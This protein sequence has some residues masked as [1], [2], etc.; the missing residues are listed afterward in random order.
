MILNAHGPGRGINFQRNRSVFRARGGAVVQGRC[1]KLDEA[2]SDVD[3]TTANDNTDAGAL[4]NTVPIVA[5]DHLTA[6]PLLQVY[7]LA[8]EAAADDGAYEGVVH[9]YWVQA[10][11]TTAAGA[12]VGEKLYLGD[13]TQGNLEDAGS[14]GI[15]TRQTIVGRMLEDNGAVTNTLQRIHFNGL[16]GGFGIDDPA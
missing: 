3:V 6:N 12:A 7:V 11:V 13:T 8:L 4:A 1:Y 16:P 2:L 14:V 9:A 15:L 5:G 10:L